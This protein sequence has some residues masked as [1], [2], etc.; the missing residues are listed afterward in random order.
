MGR[1]WAAGDGS[2]NLRRLPAA[3]MRCGPPTE[4]L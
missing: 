1:F 2:M 3:A 4:A